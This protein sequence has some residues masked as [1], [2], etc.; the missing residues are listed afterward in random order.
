MLKVVICAKRMYAC[1]K[2][3]HV[4]LG[5]GGGHAAVV[6]GPRARGLGGRARALRAALQHTWPVAAAGTYAL[7]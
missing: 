4:P 6:G 3:L 7:P 5:A 1:T 2:L